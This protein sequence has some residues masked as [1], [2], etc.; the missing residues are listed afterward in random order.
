M[1]VLPLSVFFAALWDSASLGNA[2]SEQGH[3][4]RAINSKIDHGLN[5]EVYRTLPLHGPLTASLLV[6]LSSSAQYVSV[7]V[8]GREW[9]SA[10]DSRACW[11]VDPETME[12]WP[13]TETVQHWPGGTGSGGPLTHIDYSSGDTM[14]FAQGFQLMTQYCRLAFSPEPASKVCRD[15]QN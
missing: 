1:L 5:G 9:S 13:N 8:S 6:N 14:P 12:A 4:L 10:S 2:R 11:L 7:R 3:S 15:S